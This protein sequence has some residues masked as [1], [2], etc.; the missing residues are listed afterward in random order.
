MNQNEAT[1]QAKARLS[2]AKKGW[3]L[4]RNNV[5]V[6]VDAKGRPVRFGLCNDSKQVNHN[7][8]SG[9]LIGIRPIL[10]TAD[11]VGQTIG[12]FVS[13]ECKHSGWIPNVRDGED[14]VK[15]QMKWAELVNRA[16][17]HAVF[18]TTGEL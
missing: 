6:L 16:G 15:A 4:W 9:D 1:I 2:A 11:M 18:T 13:V 10:I 12:Q 8:K 7:V 17:G 3:Q 5:G 14:R